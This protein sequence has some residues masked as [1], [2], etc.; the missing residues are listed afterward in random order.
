[1]TGQ[2]PA[3]VFCCNGPQHRKDAPPCPRADHHD[4]PKV[5]AVARH[6]PLIPHIF[7]LA[8]ALADASP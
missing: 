7:L 8:P 1:M 3:P 2:P 6:Q 4:S 5:P